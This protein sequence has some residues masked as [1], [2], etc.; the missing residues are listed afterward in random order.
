[1]VP[2]QSFFRFLQSILIL[3]IFRILSHLRYVFTILFTFFLPFLLFSFFITRFS[4]L[5]PSSFLLPT[6]HFPFNRYFLHC[7]VG[8]GCRIHRLLLCRG[9][10]TSVLNMILNNLMVRFQ[11]CWSFAE[12]GVPLHCHCSQVHSGP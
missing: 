11:Q 12:C 9:V 7:P 8:W 4:F 3:E 10:T 1:M 6:H 5:K 2:Y